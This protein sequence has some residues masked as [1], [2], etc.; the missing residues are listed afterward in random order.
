MGIDVDDA[1][2][3]WMPSV[4]MPAWEPVKDCAEAP[5]LLMAMATSAMEMRSPAERSMSISRAGAESV[6]WD[7]RSRS[8]SVVSPMAETTTTTSLPSL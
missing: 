3:P 2:L 6:T 1:A 5:S 7:A 8:S 4:I